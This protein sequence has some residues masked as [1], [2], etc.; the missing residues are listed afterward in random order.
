MSID[1]RIA[2]SSGFS[3]LSCEK[4]FELLHSLR[5][6]SDA[7]MIGANTAIKDDPSLTVRRYVGRSPIR[8][9]VDAKLRVTPNLRMFSVPRRGVLIT[10]EDHDQRELQP[11]EDR[12]VIVIRAGRGDE[13]N[14]NKALSALWDLGVR[15]LL[16]EGGGYTTYS[17]IKDYLVDELWVTVSPIILGSGTP[18]IHG[19]SD[20]MIDAYLVG[21][22][23]M[24]GGWVN[25][26]YKIIK[27]AQL[28]AA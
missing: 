17:L 8:V 9:V 22:K 21:I 1:G 19:H 15:R 5:A 18:I 2:S 11:Y 16:V 24:C 13:V 28:P 27:K 6:W 25:L 14:L 3:Q 4:D 10:T 26:R 20:L 12:G 7:V 23:V